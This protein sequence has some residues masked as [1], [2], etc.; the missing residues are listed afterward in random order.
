LLLLILKKAEFENEMNNGKKQSTKQKSQKR[1]QIITNDTKKK[2]INDNSDNEEIYSGMS[3]YRKRKRVDSDHDD[4]LDN[5]KN[6][7]QKLCEHNSNNVNHDDDTD[8]HISCFI[9]PKHILKVSAEIL[10]DF[11]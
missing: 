2:N 6:D 7:E 5:E 11:S 3:T 1:K 10:M 4:H 9:Q 8:E